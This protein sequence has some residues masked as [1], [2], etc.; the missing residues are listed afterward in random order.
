MTTETSPT[1]PPLFD[2]AP[3]ETRTKPWLGWIGP[4][5][6]AAILVAVLFM[7]RTLP[8]EAVVAV[9]PTSPAFWIVFGLYLVFP[10]LFDFAI[11]R[12][13]WR[14]P[15]EGLIAL[16]R[17]Q[18]SNELLLGY[19]G[20]VYF[21]TWARRKIDMKT[22]P[23][24][25]V[26]DVAI[27]SAL[28]G[29]AVTLVMIAIAAPLVTGGEFTVISQ[30]LRISEGWLIASLAIIVLMP[31]LAVLFGRRL[32][33]LSA[34]QLLTITVIHTVRI[35]CIMGLAALAWNLALPEVDLSWWILLST[36]RLLI[37]RLP[38]VTQ[39]D[40]VFAGIAVF[41]VGR[42]LEIAALIAFWAAIQ[43]MANVTI[44]TILAIGEFVTVEKKR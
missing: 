9:V 23:F 27:L 31:M 12:Y 30:K 15:P 39:K 3:L 14:I 13:L 11:F 41:L 2:P 42:D 33:S 38:F 25:A 7:L 21:Y 37:S 24:G 28:A 16:T 22:S 26:K 18:V 20:E 40:I 32:F 43:L 36:V 10:I 17:K 4:I 44:G 1:V 29:N 6:S 5:I 34:R 19:L 8:W 35:L